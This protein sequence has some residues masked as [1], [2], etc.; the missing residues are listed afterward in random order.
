MDAV[1]LEKIFDRFTRLNFDQEG[2]GF[3]IG[4]SAEHCTLS[5][6]QA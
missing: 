4:Y 1:Q 5:S 6:D 2:Q 3:G